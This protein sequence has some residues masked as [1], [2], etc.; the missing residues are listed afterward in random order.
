MQFS[1]PNISAC[2]ILSDKGN[3]SGP[4]L[5]R[6]AAPASNPYNDILLL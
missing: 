3:K 1:Y 2:P 4:P 5:D 6:L